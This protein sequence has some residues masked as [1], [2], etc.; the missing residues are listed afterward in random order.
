MNTL[1]QIKAD[2]V[3]RSSSGLLARLMVMSP[4]LGLWARAAASFWA[5]SLESKKEC[6]HYDQCTL[7]YAINSIYHK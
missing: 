3:P 7:P 6:T 4:E 5:K 1:D 2:S